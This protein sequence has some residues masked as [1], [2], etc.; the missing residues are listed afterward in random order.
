[1]TRIRRVIDD[2][3]VFYTN[4]GHNEKTWTDKR[5]LAHVEGGLRWA[6]GLVESDATPNPALQT[7]LEATREELAQAQRRQ[8]AELDRQRHFLT[9]AGYLEHRIPR[10][11][12]RWPAPWPEI[13]WGTEV[14]LADWL[15]EKSG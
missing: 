3:R 9:F 6:L 14:L 10:A 5:F 15:L 1:M 2:G 13:F 12:G 8:Q 4:L 7:E 11:W